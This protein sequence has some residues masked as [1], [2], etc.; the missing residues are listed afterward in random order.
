LGQRHASIGRTVWRARLVD[1]LVDVLKRT[2]V[3]FGFIQTTSTPG[4]IF[5]G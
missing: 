3:I 1:V 4:R 5:R 2:A